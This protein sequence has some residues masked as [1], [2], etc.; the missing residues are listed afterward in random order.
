MKYPYDTRIAMAEAAGVS[1]Q[2]LGQW[3]K[4]VD[5]PIGREP[6]WSDTDVEMLAAFRMW[7]SEDPSNGNGDRKKTPFSLAGVLTARLRAERIQSLR[8]E[9][10]LKANKYVKVVN[11][12]EAFETYC[13]LVR[14]SLMRLPS[15]LTPRLSTAVTEMIEA[16]MRRILAET[17]KKLMMVI[18]GE[19]DTDGA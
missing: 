18:E 11:V 8:F 17:S 16:E 9:R 14:D 5:F 12:R 1:R 6:P 4:R 19:T 7:L 2:T 13:T 15:R 3:M 10:E